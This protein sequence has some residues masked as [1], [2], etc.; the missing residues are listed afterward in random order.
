VSRGSRLSLV[1]LAVVLMFAPAAA[2]HP[3]VT[4]LYA[5]GLSNLSIE[6]THPNLLGFFIVALVSVL[7]AAGF[8]VAIMSATHG[9]TH[10][11]ALTRIS[12]EA[13][14]EDF[15]YRLLPLDTVM[16]FTAGVIRPVT[17]VSEGAER[18]LGTAGLRAALLHEEAHR[19]SQDI[20]WRLLLGAVGRGF[21]FFPWM[22]E[23]VESETLRTECAADDYAI[24]EGA[25]RLDL[26]DAIVAASAPPASPLVAGLSDAHVELR[27][28]RL[29]DPE[30]PL[31]GRPTRSFIALTA[32]VVLPALGAHLIAVAAA[33]GTSRL[34]M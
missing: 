21:G 33:V 32:A 4:H 12:R 6:F 13:Q 29:V 19:R 1:T 8:T 14:M 20:L 34:M 31:P 17:F 28:M 5:A 22:S 25:R 15:Q 30:T 2:L 3:V 23:V 24:R 7:P 11:R 18:A 27:L 16:V 26:F 9:A 10:L